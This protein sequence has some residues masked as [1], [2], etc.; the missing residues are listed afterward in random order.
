MVSGGI[1]VTTA[2][3]RASSLAFP[4]Q[5]DIKCVL[6]RVRSACTRMFHMGVHPIIGAFTKNGMH[7][8]GIVVLK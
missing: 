5:T 6:A 4:V 7:Y 8:I 2:R 1:S 3:L